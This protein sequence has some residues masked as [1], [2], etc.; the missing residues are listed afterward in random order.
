MKRAVKAAVDKSVA[1]ARSNAVMRDIGADML[2]AIVLTS[3]EITPPAEADA[4]VRTLSALV[5]AA[6]EGLV[7]DVTLAG[8][9]GGD[10]AHIADHAGCTLSESEYP[11]NVLR[12]A[13]S[14][15]RG[16]QI[17]LIRA[18]HAPDAGFI[19]EIADFLARRQIATRGALLRERPE[20]LLARTFPRFAPAAGLVAPRDR[21]LSLS[22]TNFKELVRGAKPPLTLRSRARRVS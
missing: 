21:L 16:P 18:G 19:E 12:D 9:I 5:P 1:R 11:R 8:M 10:L 20:S 15:A 7:R 13:I 4:V 17:F 22:A 2:S 14:A 6:I 3:D